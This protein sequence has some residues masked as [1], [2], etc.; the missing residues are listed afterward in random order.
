LK[1]EYFFI[2]IIFYL[3]VGPGPS[4]FFLNKVTISFLPLLSLVASL[5]ILRKEII[6]YD[7]NMNLKNRDVYRWYFWGLK[8]C[9][10]AH[11]LCTILT[12]T[13]KIITDDLIEH[14]LIMPIYSVIIGPI[15]EE[16]VY[17]KIIYGSLSNRYNFWTGAVVS[18][19]IFSIGHLNLE[20][21]LAYFLTGLVLCYTYKKTNTITTP[22][23]IH[24]TLNLIA[25]LVQTLKG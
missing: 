7:L 10:F 23:L 17:R 4:I 9:L 1:K 21:L 2:L 8:Y 19:L 15:F 13:S 6:A 12:G 16:I 14:Y 20:R 3:F 11:A 25:I 5:W 24:A 18:S 22:I